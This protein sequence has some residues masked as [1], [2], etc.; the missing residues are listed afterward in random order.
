M[1]TW[2]AFWLR[3]G[4]YNFTG[5]MASRLASLGMRNSRV[6]YGLADMTPKGY[7]HP[8]AEIIDVDL[9]LGSNVFIGE[10]A[11]VA[12]WGGGDAFIELRD[13]VQINRDCSLE[14]GPGGSIV[15]GPQ[16]GLE[17]GCVLFSVLEPIIIKSRAEIAA[18]CSFF[19]YDHGIAAGREIYGQPV[20]SKGPI[21][22]EE[23]AWLGVGVTVLSGVTIGRGAVV[24]AGS[25]V[26][27]DIP[28]NAIA[29]GAPARVVKYREPS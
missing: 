16:T 28:A 19:S 1:K 17:S 22:V 3:R 14:V 9:R 25:V 20:T 6:R 4:G 11:L 27:R 12:H 5:R 24:G 29:A 10:R 23:D 26:T 8:E 2:R 7:I 18:N 15:I 13:R 21:V